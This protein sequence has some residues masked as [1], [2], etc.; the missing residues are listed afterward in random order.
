MFSQNDTEKELIRHITK[1]EVVSQLTKAAREH[2]DGKFGTNNFNINININK[3]YHNAESAPKTRGSLNYM[4]AKQYL[5]K[6]RRKSHSNTITND[7]P[8]PESVESKTLANYI[9]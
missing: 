4:E 5:E 3:N 6:N 2:A 7:T 8:E 1:P 9:N